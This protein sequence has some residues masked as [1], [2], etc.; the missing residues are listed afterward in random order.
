MAMMTGTG[1]VLRCAW[2]RQRPTLK[3]LPVVVHFDQ[4]LVNIQFVRKKGSRQKPGD[5]LGEKK[6]IDLRNIREAN[7]NAFCHHHPAGCAN[8]M[9]SIMIVIFANKFIPFPYIL[10]LGRFYFRY[11]KNMAYLL[12]F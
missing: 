11:F 5:G 7:R 9:N 2:A 10:F 3:I 12:L 4:A 1:T 8:I 6:C